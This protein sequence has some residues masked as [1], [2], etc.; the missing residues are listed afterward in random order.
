VPL[1]ADGRL[2]IYNSEG[3]TDVLV[4]VTGWFTDASDPGAS[5]GFYTGVTP[6]RILDTRDGTG[7]IGARLGPNTRVPLAIAGQPGMP[8][9]GAVKLVV[10]NL[11]AVGATAASYLSVGP[12]S[13]GAAATSDLNFAPSTVV[14]NLVVAPV[15]PDGKVYIYNSEGE[16]HALADLVGWYG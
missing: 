2:S 7:G 11:T 16:T 9:S 8:T 10:L 1:S 13:G 15:S 4:D 14:S 5:G 12:G 3:T 6:V